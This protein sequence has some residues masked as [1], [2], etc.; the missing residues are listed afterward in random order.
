M[1]LRLSNVSSRVRYVVYSIDRIKP[2]RFCTFM[3]LDF[4]PFVSMRYTHYVPLWI[5]LLLLWLLL[6]VVPCRSRRCCCFWNFT[7]FLCFHSLVLALKNID[8]DLRVIRRYKCQLKAATTIYTHHTKMPFLICAQN[9]RKMYLH[10]STI[11]FDRITIT[12]AIMNQELSK[13][14]NPKNQRNKSAK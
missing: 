2:L 3:S 8:V 6:L 4:C 7:F 11:Y 10:V 14:E 12:V 5:L 1:A 9:Q 13:S